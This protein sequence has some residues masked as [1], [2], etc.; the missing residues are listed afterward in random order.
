MN[1]LKYALAAIALVASA[2]VHASTLDPVIDAF[3]LDTLV[4]TNAVKVLDIRADQE[5]F[6]KA[7]IPGALSIPYGQFR[8]PKENPGK[9]PELSKLADILGQV[10]LNPEDSVVV[11]A[12]G[13]T[14]SDFGAAARVYWTLK[15]VGFTDLAIL[16]GGFR[17]YQKD[18]FDLSNTPSAVTV[19]RP[20]LSFDARWYANTATV[21]EAVGGVGEARLLDAR[22]AAFFQGEAWHDA[23][24]RPGSL[25]GAD[26]FAFEAFF[27]ANTPLLKDASEIQSIVRANQ[28]DAPA[29]ISYCNTG[30][31]AATNW[32]V[33]SEVAAVPNVKLYAESMVE[34][35]QTGQAMDHVPSAIRFAVLKTK[36]WLDGWVN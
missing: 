19:S 16:N 33:L 29:T 7:H 12:E 31:W 22:P 20:Q 30:H 10:G 35:S 15:S 18:G 25:P 6:A 28:L 1:A 23:A 27:D 8:G 26:H 34:W 3:T 4:Q 17:A 9:L 32:F 5:A 11:V 36:K 14:T 21:T 24:A 2:G 13:V